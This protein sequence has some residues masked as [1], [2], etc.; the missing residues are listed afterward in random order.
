M[1][2]VLGTT[3]AISTVATIIR[4]AENPKSFVIIG[5]ERVY[6]N[7]CIS[8]DGYCNNIHARA[9]PKYQVVVHVLKKP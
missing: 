7:S 1:V 4:C 3:A 8:H 2:N 6:S 5:D 9:E